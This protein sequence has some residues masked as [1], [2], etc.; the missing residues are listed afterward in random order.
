MRK[1]FFIFPVIIVFFIIMTGQDTTQPEK[2]DMPLQSGI[3]DP[4][5]T[6][7]APL[8]QVFDYFNPN[9]VTRIIR[10]PIGVMEVTPNIR[11]L[12][13]TNSYQ[14]EVD[15]KRHPLNPNIMFASSNAFNNVSGSLFI[16]E[17]VYVTTNG[18]MNWFGSDTLTGL[19]LGNHGGDPGITIDKNGNFI[20]THLGFSTSGMFANYSTDNGLTWSSNFTLTT[21][22]QDKNFATTDDAPSSSYY[23]RS[24]CVWSLFNLSSPPIGISWTTNGGVSWTTPPLQINTSAAGHYSQGVDAKVGPNGEVYV[25]WAAPT[26][27]SPFTEDFAGFAKSTNG[28]SNWTVTDNAFDMNGIRGTFASKSG[29]RVNSF[30]RIDVDRSGGSRNG[31]IYVATSGKNIAPAGTD[32]DILLYSSSNGGTNWTSGVRVNQDPLNNG[33]FQWIPAIRVDEA[34]GVNIV[35]Y[36]D[37]NTSSDSGEVYVSRSLDGGLTFTDVLVSDHR[38]KPKPITV[39]GIAGGYQGDYIGV[40][41]GS[42]KLWPLW[43]DDITGVYQ[44]WTA[45]VQIQTFPLN[46]FNITSPTAGTRIQTLPNNTT[47]YTFNWDTSASTASYKWIFGSPTTSPRKITLQPIGNSITVTGG[48]LDNI[49]AGL[50]LAQG[51]SLVG[52]WDVWAF[53]NNQA[54]DS[55]KAANGPRALTLKRAKPLLT[56]FNL[57]SPPN[58]TTLL[59]LITNTTPV[60]I[61]WTKSGEAVKFKWMFARPNFSATSNIKFI[62]NSNNSGFDTNLTLRNSQIDSLLAG[63]GVVVGDSAVGQWRVYGYSANDSLASS[64]TFNLTLRRGIPPT[65]TTSLDSISVNLPVGQTATRNFTIGN[66]GQFPL[67]W[68]I[69]ESSLS[70]DNLSV[71]NNEDKDAINNVIK[72]LPKGATHNY[73]GPEVTDAQGGPDA[74]GYTWIDSDE[75]GGPV[76]NWVDISTTGTPIT[77]WV[78]GTA[79]D[80]SVIVALP[81][82][83]PYYGSNYSQLKICT[84]GWVGFDVASTIT[85]FSNLT[86][87]T[88]AQPNN[89]LYPFWDDQDFRVSGT[90]YY[91]NDAENNRFIVMYKDAPHYTPPGGGPYTY[92]VIIYNDGRI[93][94]QYLNMNAPLNS[95]TIGTENSDGTIGLEIV[96]DNTYV[97][98]NLA[99]KIEKGLGWVDEVPSSGT[100]TPSGNQN[101]A[102]N[103]NSAGLL[104]NSSYVGNLTVGTNDPLTPSKIVRVRL[105]VG[106]VG[107]SNPVTGIPTEFALNQNYPNPF[108]PSTKISYALPKDGF[109][110]I[111]IYDI[112]GKQIATLI[113]EN[114]RAGYYDVQFNADNFSSGMYFYHIV[115]HP[116]SGAFASDKIEA[117]NFS[118]TKK[119]LL[120]K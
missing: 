1:L 5:V 4:S 26:S 49:L 101:V 30:P 74:G 77:T 48:Q 88:T 83:F 3:Y 119:M 59:T 51:D 54:N 117:E 65:V 114:K 105:N 50:G 11:V 28:G 56:T 94:Y 7:S 46:A 15:I 86:I 90:V 93:Y 47:S 84:N 82:S 109:V 115:I 66:T 9:S 78:N 70:L 106:P 53:R 8:P 71:K 57:S 80:G 97:H 104:S 31:W 116:H 24:Y 43:A 79:D 60:N 16:S 18:G 85:A 29:I 111:K 21:G 69:T 102:V 107:I 35:Y 76:F 99:I 13:R 38:F 118:D 98:N 61:N 40:T 92:E 32:P 6:F 22:S 113:D 112:L 55:M 58:N 100:I 67:N 34:G 37:R 91:R 33:K 75:P 103:F 68:V 41:S 64:Q 62:L 95:N 108:N 23:G 42:G 44:A 81:F 14:S 87:P 36:D 27:A 12:P 89:C 39:G 96:F 52:Q 17:G 25:I 120:I 73:H 2:W 20:M 110:S 19:P 72:T 45:G 10:T 63:I